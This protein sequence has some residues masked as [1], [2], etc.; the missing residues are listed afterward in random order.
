MSKAIDLARA[1]LKGKALTVSRGQ[2][3]LAAAGKGERA[4][5]RARRP[6]SSAPGEKIFDRSM[7][8]R[9]RDSIREELCRQEA[10]LTSKDP[11]LSAAMS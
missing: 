2:R 4:L 8:C 1:F 7:R 6:I 11:E 3:T 10:M 5:A 9:P